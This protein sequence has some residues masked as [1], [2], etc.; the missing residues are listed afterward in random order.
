MLWCRVLSISVGNMSLYCAEQILSSTTEMN[1]PIWKIVFMMS[2]SPH[3]ICNGAG[4]ISRM[5]TPSRY[6]A[7]SSRAERLS[8]TLSLWRARALSLSLSLFLSLSL[9]LS[10]SVSDAANRPVAPGS[11]SGIQGSRCTI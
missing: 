6:A 10:L 3:E 7:G 4:I 1:R 8:M 5:L 9:S 2:A 11:G